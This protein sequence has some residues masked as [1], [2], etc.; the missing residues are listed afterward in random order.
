MLCKTILGAMSVLLSACATTPDQQTPE[1]TEPPAP[2]VLGVAH[3]G[4][5][6]DV[7]IIPADVQYVFYPPGTIPPAT[8]P[9]GRE[10]FSHDDKDVKP[11]QDKPMASASGE[12][13]TLKLAAVDGAA[14]VPSNEEILTAW[15]KF[16]AADLDI[17]PA[18]WAIIDATPVPPELAQHWTRDC[19]PSK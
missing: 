12:P 14:S 7:V 13:R 19:V 3:V 1:P 18:E 6:S 16:C 17:S 8:P 5:H 4:I 15:R 2:P 10:S 9:A 11:V